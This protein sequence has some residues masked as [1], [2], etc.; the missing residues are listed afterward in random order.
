MTSFVFVTG[1]ANKLKEVQA[2]LA[3]GAS[4]VSVTSQAVDVPEIQGTTQEVA[5]AKVKA[6]AEKLG[7]ACV[8]EDTALCFDALNGLP[9]P[10]I[11]DF[12]GTLGHEGLNNLL[13]GF[14]TTRA[15]AL[16]TFAYSPGPGQE[17][18]L[19]EGRTEGNIVPARGP[20]HFGWD[21]IFQPIELGG[22]KT[23]AEMDGEEKNKIS[24]RYRALE[25][26]RV[27]LQDKA[28]EGN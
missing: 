21:P 14:N 24:H 16:C 27:Y 8:T 13:K 19:F 28:K 9:G 18:I 3:S 26:L 4:G 6:A 25:K 1:N 2:I 22:Q 15:H 10:Y 20:T 23:Y 12:L 7:T 17:P 5:I 11:K